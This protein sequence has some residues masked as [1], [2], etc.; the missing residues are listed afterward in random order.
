[1]IRVQQEDFDPG[2]ELERLRLSLQGSA[3]GVVSFI[4]L[5]RE[6]NEGA[7]ITGMTLEHYPGM[8]E[9]ALG[10]IA[11]EATERWKLIDAVIIH[12]IGPLAPNDRIVLV[13]AASEH[14]KHAF[15]ACEF[16]I[17]ALKTNAPFWKKETTPRGSRWITTAAPHPAT[18]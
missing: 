10:A 7:A 12:R 1:M 14:R 9:K 16:M 4:G 3:G 13:I 18:E 5:V 6:L 11:V 2:A 15:R 8:T 17:D